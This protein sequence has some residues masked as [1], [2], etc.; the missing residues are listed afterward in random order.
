MLV[1]LI[2]WH[3]ESAFPKNYAK[4]VEESLAAFGLRSKILFLSLWT[5]FWHGSRMT[6]A[7]D[8]EAA[9]TLATEPGAPGTEDIPCTPGH[10]E[11]REQ[12]RVLPEPAH[13]ALLLPRWDAS[14]VPGNDAGVEGGRA[15]MQP[16]LI[17]ERELVWLGVQ[18]G[19]LASLVQYLKYTVRTSPPFQSVILNEAAYFFLKIIE[20]ASG[21]KCKA[22]KK[23]N[24]NIRWNRHTLTKDWRKI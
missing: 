16:L 9:P 10:C 12:R 24:R 11:R 13:A 2:P 20:I 17:N 15:R 23:K 7:S 5:L 4:I 6:Q 1:S 14:L 21:K 18:Q 19:C 22:N 3:Q 8:A